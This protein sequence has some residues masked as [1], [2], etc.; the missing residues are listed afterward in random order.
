MSKILL[1][2]KQLF[3]AIRNKR[4]FTL[5]EMLFAFSVFS[6]IIFF[7]SPIFQVMLTPINSQKR[8]DS[9]E[10]DVFSSQLKKEIRMSTKVQASPESLILTEDAG[11]VIIERYEDSLRRRVNYS[12]HEIVLQ[13]ISKVNFSLLKNAVKVTVTDVFGVEYRLVVYP[14]LNWS[15][16]T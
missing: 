6:M 2:R 8:L 12:G 4:A 3:A 10:W 7:I 16:S 9:M 15:G 11:T 13:H 5:V 14:V 1:I